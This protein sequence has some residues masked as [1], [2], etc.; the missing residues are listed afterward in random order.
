ME[1]IIN[2]LYDTDKIYGFPEICQEANYNVA[3]FDLIEEEIAGSLTIT[4]SAG[5]FE[6]LCC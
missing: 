3:F 2:A 4:K 6:A 5:M 1:N